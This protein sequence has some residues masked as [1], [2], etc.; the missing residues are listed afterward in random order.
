MR[1]PA[2]SASSL[3]LSLGLGI[4]AVCM[5]A[6]GLYCARLRRKEE[7]LAAAAPSN[8]AFSPPWLHPSSMPWRTGAQPPRPTP[9]IATDAGPEAFR[10]VFEDMRQSILDEL[11]RQCAAPDAIEH[12]DRM[13]QYNVPHGK[14]VRGM[15]VVQAFR[16]MAPLASGEAIYRAMA[17]G[18]VLEWSQAAA[19][20]QDDIM[21]SAPTRRGKTSWYRVP[22]VGYGAINDG[23]ILEN[24]IFTLLRANF[25]R[26]EYYTRLVSFVF[27]LLYVTE[28]G[29]LLDV[30]TPFDDFSAERWAEIV[31]TKTGIYTFYAPLHVALELA[32]VR[33]QPAYERAL[34]FA[35]AVGEY[36]QA[37]DDFLDCYGDAAKMGKEGTD[38]E[39]GKCSWLVVEALRR[40][41]A[42]QRATLQENYG[43]DEP[44]RI[45]AVKRVYDELELRDAFRAFEA[46]V[47]T[48][49]HEEAARLD[50]RLAIVGQQL[51][52]RLFK[53]A[54]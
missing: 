22:D 32:G 23:L 9:R 6:V 35:L 3:E 16:A 31:R 40:A 19:L 7:A 39:N 37:Q 50:G 43:V 54:A 49:L 46:S 20:V 24:Q 44:A 4:S 14:C 27:D 17:A 29:Q 42:A 30:R 21:D 53:R 8:S 26:E 38:I 45:A 18:W 10:R 25:E 52:Q 36:F 48:R 1:T 51:L 11:Q 12:I 13:V 5:L 47:S 15:L 41:S 33:A 28:R 2:A 34:S